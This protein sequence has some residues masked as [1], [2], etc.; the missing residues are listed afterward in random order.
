MPRKP[1][2]C[3]FHGTAGNETIVR[4]QMKKFID[5]YKDEFDISVVEA[6]RCMTNNF[7]PRVRDM[8]PIFG[9]HVILREWLESS[10]Q[11]STD[12]AKAAWGML[13][14]DERL[15]KL[16]KKV[17]VIVG[18]SAGAQM[19][20]LMAARSMIEPKSHPPFRA[21]V[22]LCPPVPKDFLEGGQNEEDTLQYFQEPLEIPVLITHATGDEIVGQEGA[23]EFAKLFKAPERYSHEGD[24]RPFPEDDDSAQK[25]CA[26]IK[27]FIDIHT[28]S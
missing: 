24:H 12:Y 28:K 22:M 21:I 18:F 8:R 5:Q 10:M 14:T 20:A 17:D 26:K 27:D 16:N 1:H 9:K 13:R 19:A 23:D 3:L 6:P 7:H 11:G 4:F 2:V 25:L 15:Q